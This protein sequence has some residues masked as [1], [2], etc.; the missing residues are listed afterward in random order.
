MEFLGSGTAIRHYYLLEIYLAMHQVY[1][2]NSNEILIK[3]IISN[4]QDL[5]ANLNVH[6][7]K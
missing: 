7:C 3:L 1:C 5:Q 4:V 6:V 2:D